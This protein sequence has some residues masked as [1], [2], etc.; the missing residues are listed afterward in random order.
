MIE[1]LRLLQE[2]G[3]VFRLGFTFTL[4]LHAGTGE[5]SWAPINLSVSVDHAV[6]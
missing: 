2:V 1:K 4:H 5:N 3:L 6:G